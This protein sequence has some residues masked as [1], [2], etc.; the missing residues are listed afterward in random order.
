M[1]PN[2]IITIVIIENYRYYLIIKYD[3]IRLVYGVCNN[4]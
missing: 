4:R 1:N 3:E 2:K